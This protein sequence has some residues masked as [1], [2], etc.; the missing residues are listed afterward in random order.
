MPYQSVNVSRRREE[1]VDG[2]ATR[3]LLF[4]QADFV[5]VYAFHNRRNPISG[6]L[7]QA[8]EGEEALAFFGT[9]L[10]NWLRVSVGGDFGWVDTNEVTVQLVTKPVPLEEEK[11]TP[12]KRGQVTSTVSAD[13]SK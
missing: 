13:A 10:D 1:G 12:K 8:T 2:V 11:P 9:Q 3:V 5:P 6:M 4:P 7:I